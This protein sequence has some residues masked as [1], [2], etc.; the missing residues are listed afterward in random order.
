MAKVGL[1][2]N[3]QTHKVK[4]K[5]PQRTNT[6][7]LTAEVISHEFTGFLKIEFAAVGTVLFCMQM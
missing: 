6:T 7:T 1:I 2:D 3:N 4:N 5:G